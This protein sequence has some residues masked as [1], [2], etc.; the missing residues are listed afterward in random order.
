VY[1]KCSRY[2]KSNNSLKILGI[3]CL[4]I[5][6][7]A[8][9]ITQSVPAKGYEASIYTATPPVFWVAMLLN[10]ICGTFIIIQQIR[11]KQHLNS[12]L[13]FI[14]FLLVFLAFASLVTLWIIRGYVNYGTGDPLSH[15]ALINYIISNYHVPPNDLYPITHILT[16][17][18]SYVINIP[19][20]GVYGYIPILFNIL[21]LI[22]MFV[23]AKTILSSKGAAI[24]TVI[25]AMIT[26]LGFSNG[27]VQFT[28][29]ILADLYLPFALFLFV[30]SS[31]SGTTLWK[32]LFIVV[33][34]MY[35]VFHPV[36]SFA[37][38]LIVAT[39][40]IANIFIAIL[41]VRHLYSMR[42]LFK[43]RLPIILFL[44]VWSITWFS[45]GTMWATTINNLR[46]YFSGIGVSQLTVL[47]QLAQKA[48]QYQYNVPLEIIKIYGG[49]V[50]FAVI[51][52]ATLFVILKKRLLETEQKN[53]L[54]LYGPL[55]IITL[56]VIVFYLV[57]ITFSPLRLIA[58]IALILSILTAFG[59]NKLLER[60]NSTA[61]GTFRNYL[62][63]GLVIFVIAATFAGS[64]LELYPSRY[65]LQPN[66]Q[67]TRTNLQGMG[68]FFN[69][70]NQ[71]E[72]L[73]VVSNIVPSRYA[74]YLL[75]PQEDSEQTN[76]SPVILEEKEGIVMP[77]HFGYNEH[78]EL[79][80][81]Y[82]QQT[83]LLVDQADRVFFQEVLP[84]MQ[85][86]RFTPEDFDKLDQDP[87]VEKIYSNGG[88]DIYVV[89]P[90]S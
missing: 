88:L 77:Y 15:V 39:V 40:T 62:L 13:W 53:I 72:Q 1:N 83:Y 27:N 63:S 61:E 47:T 23:L 73:S 85:A 71:T 89:T 3:V 21:Y 4:I 78:D 90:T 44:L 51:S 22:S 35:P 65:I 86:A 82:S 45:S 67:V 26:I 30:K 68:W 75:S 18:I 37:L 80:Y 50:I 69:Y 57:N 11:T 32:I 14:G 59:L 74:D 20:T 10:V 7:I 66:D 49:L 87:S 34:F 6:I 43:F 55:A 9:L 8:L 16:A 41:K 24:V 48:N 81:W 56:F 76:L 33:V 31:P 42:G 17:E 46:I 28:P 84:E 70:R 36:T 12:S 25:V 64:V 5:F 29:N 52:L 54:S 2:D 19:V 58:Y 38:L 60:A 79:G